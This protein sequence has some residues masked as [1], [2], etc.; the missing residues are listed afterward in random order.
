MFH[1]SIWGVCV[2]ERDR[3]RERERERYKKRSLM[4]T[5]YAPASTSCEVP[6]FMDVTDKTHKKG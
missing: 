6:L 1:K 3:D 5:S 2:W 4:K